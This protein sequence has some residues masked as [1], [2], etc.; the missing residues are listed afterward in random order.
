MRLSLAILIIKENKTPLPAILLYASKGVDGILNSKDA[1]TYKDAYETI[2][3]NQ[4]KMKS[5]YTKPQEM[6]A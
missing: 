5:P 2:I 3:W 4:G 6:E 1:E